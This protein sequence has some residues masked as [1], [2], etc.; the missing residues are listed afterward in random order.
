MLLDL[1][2][3]KFDLPS[4]ALSS[5]FNIFLSSPPKDI[6]NNPKLPDRPNDLANNF[7]GP[8]H[9]F[10]SCGVPVT[11]RPSYAKTGHTGQSEGLKSLNNTKSNHQNVFTINGTIA[12]MSIIF[13]S[14]ERGDRS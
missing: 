11:I 13:L 14:N 2:E 1:L 4:E 8:Y 5:T 9:I 10:S 3:K 7:G 12:I 6:K